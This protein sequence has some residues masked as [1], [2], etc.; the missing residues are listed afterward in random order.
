MKYEE[1]KE[2]ILVGIESPY[3]GDV[4]TNIRY[5]KACVLDC[6]RRGEA[7]YAS[8]LFFTQDDL[9]DDN[10]PD[11]RMLGIMAGKAW[12]KKAQYTVV[13]TDRGISKGM[14]FGIELAKKEGRPILYRALGGEWTCEASACMPVIKDLDRKEDITIDE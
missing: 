5:A 10:D 2:L 3:A 12:E 7:P 13:Y 11:E 6:L 8:H 1:N 9:L 14:K 4:E